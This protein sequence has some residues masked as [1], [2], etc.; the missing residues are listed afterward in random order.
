MQ[1]KF[2]V[3]ILL[4]LSFEFVCGQ[5]ESNHSLHKKS[6]DKEKQG[7]KIKNH[8]PVKL[9]SSLLPRKK[10]IAYKY[11]ALQDSVD[12]NEILIVSSFKAK[13]RKELGQYLNL[14]RKTKKVW[15]YALMAADRLTTLRDRLNSIESKSGKRR[16]TKI[17]QRYIEDRFAEKLKNL[18]HSEGQI[19]IKLMYR[20]TGETT[21]DIIRELRSGF[22][23][24]F[25]NIT[26][27][28]FTISLKDKY[29]PKKVKEDYYIEY[30]LRRAF[31]KNQLEYQK[32]AIDIDFSELVNKWE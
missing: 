8:N 2:C 17:V 18:T 31:Q 6:A 3:Y 28:L 7:F 4:F 19:L 11:S 14:R 32:P 30:I 22:R 25:Y 9:D 20:Q 26:A 1:L 27:N 23:A 12:L 16:Y 5:V 29:E 15:P 21:F 13:N 24:F 10:E